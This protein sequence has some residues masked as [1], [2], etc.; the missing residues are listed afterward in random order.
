[1]VKSLDSGSGLLV[2]ELG[3]GRHRGSCL[4]RTVSVLQ[5]K[6]VLEMG[7]EDGPL[8]M[9]KYLASLKCTLRMVRMVNFMFCVTHSEK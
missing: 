3:R 7:G 4:V 6:T 5:M 8:I 2:A 9:W 1:M